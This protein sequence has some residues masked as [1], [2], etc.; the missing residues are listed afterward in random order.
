M[1]DVDINGHVMRNPT[2]QLWAVYD[3]MDLV[4]CAVNKY[5]SFWCE[6]FVAAG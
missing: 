6:A 5:D 1:V 3:G 4:P 2:C